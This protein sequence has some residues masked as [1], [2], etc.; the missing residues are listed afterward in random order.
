MDCPVYL[1]SMIS[2]SFC[3]GD[4]PSQL[5]EQKIYFV[6]IQDGDVVKNRPF[7]VQFGL[8]SQMIGIAPAL[9]D[10][11]DTGHQTLAFSLINSPKKLRNLALVG[12]P[13]K[14]YY[15]PQIGL[16]VKINY[17]PFHQL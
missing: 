9:V 1:F 11:P 3:D 16:K 15:N 12:Y 7:V 14:I 13:N 2:T 5:K 6:N 4:T 10:W 8:S 17:S